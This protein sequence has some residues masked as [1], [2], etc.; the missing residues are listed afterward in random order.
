MRTR[1]P[2]AFADE[3]RR[4]GGTYEPAGPDGIDVRGLPIE[5]IGELAA[6]VG[7]VLHELSPQ[8]ASLEDAFL[9]ATAHAQEYRSGPDGAPAPPAPPA[10]GPVSSPPAG[11]SFP[12][13]GAAT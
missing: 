13:P 7:A 2:A 8:S 9:S 12:A 11:G 10:P 3:L 1:R 6:R 5:Q 4:A